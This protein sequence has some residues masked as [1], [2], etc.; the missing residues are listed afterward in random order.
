[1]GHA[2]IHAQFREAICAFVMKQ[3]DVMPLGLGSK[4]GAREQPTLYGSCAEFS[5]LLRTRK[6]ALSVTLTRIQNVLG[7]S[8]VGVWKR[9]V[10]GHARHAGFSRCVSSPAAWLRSLER[11]STSTVL[12]THQTLTEYKVAQVRYLPVSCDLS[13]RGLL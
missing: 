3:T 12:P 13:T 4:W 5:P 1:L 9:H 10:C 8:V 11:R 6:L 7:L 2:W